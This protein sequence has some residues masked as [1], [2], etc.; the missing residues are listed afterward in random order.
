MSMHP[1]E[2][3]TITTIHLTIPPKQKK[4]RGWET[5][6]LLIG[7]GVV[8]TLLMI[9]HLYGHSQPPADSIDNTTHIE[10]VTEQ[11]PCEP[12]NMIHVQERD[13][14][15]QLIAIANDLPIEHVMVN[16]IGTVCYDRNNT[17]PL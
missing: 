8:S 5:A 13:R 2:I 9:S 17:P 14:L 15:I 16:E 10:T 1:W 12:V 3:N 7:I 4:Y 11:R 6:I